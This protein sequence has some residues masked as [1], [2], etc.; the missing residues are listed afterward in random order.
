MKQS[1]HSLG[2]KQIR[3]W[4]VRE[5]GWVQY[6]GQ[7]NPPSGWT[8]DAFEKFKHRSKDFPGPKVTSVLPATEC[9]CPSHRDCFGVID[10]KVPPASL[11]IEAV[12]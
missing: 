3:K 6:L 4:G 10:V 7:P 2:L 1:K 11:S 8:E 9:H 5:V 12:T